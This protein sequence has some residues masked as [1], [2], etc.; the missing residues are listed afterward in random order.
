MKLIGLCSVTFRDKSVD[1]IVDIAVENGLNFIE[2][3]ADIHLPPGDF[4]KAE[5]VKKICNKNNILC[6]Y[7]SYFK[8]K[9]DDDIN[10]ILETAE[11]L[12]AK[13]IRIW[14]KRISSKDISTLEYEKFIRISKKI[15]DK[16][17]K[18]NININ[19]E[20]HRKTLTDTTKSAEKLLK[21]IDKE[22]LYMY[23]QPQAGDDRNER[24]EAIEL[25]KDKISNVHVFNWDDE[26]NRYPLKEA[27]DEWKSYVEKLGDDRAYLLEFVKDD[28][29]EQFREDAKVLKEIIGG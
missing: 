13:D 5:R 21:D 15:C 6:S 27:R 10:L 20:N 24:I 22:N 9:E 23:W 1:E 28:S 8:Y 29:I 16:A 12:G 14:A 25:L 19:F 4:G 7:G 18:K 2:W 17:K 26:F 11:V 3:G